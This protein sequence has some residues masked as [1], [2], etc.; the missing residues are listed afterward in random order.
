MIPY[1]TIN[2]VVIYYNNLCNTFTLTAF[3]KRILILYKKKKKNVI[4][5]RDFYFYV[6]TQINL[7]L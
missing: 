5:K 1:I 2:F 6:I 3:L 7:Y 4:E